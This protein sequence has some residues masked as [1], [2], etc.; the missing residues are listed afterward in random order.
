MR[1][2]QIIYISVQQLSFTM[3]TIGER[4]EIE[5]TRAGTATQS[6]Q[7]AFI[8]LGFDASD[9]ENQKS[10]ELETNILRGLF[11]LNRTS[12]LRMIDPPLMPTE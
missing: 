3:E 2:D 7:P 1:F 5:Q 8:W 12:S 9:R 10:R 11:K 4:L 6:D